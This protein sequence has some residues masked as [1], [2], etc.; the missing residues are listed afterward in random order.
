[1]SGE[2]LHVADQQF[3]GKETGMRD[4]GIHVLCDVELDTQATASPRVTPD[5]ANCDTP[6]KAPQWRWTADPHSPSTSPPPR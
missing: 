6:H 4:R 2:R 1:M 3:F 5:R